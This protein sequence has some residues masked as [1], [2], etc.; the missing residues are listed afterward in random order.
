MVTYSLLLIAMDAQAMPDIIAHRCGTKELPENTVFA[1]EKLVI[2]GITNIEIDLQLTKDGAP[3]LYHADNLLKLNLD[4]QISDYTYGELAE[5]FWIDKR[6]PDNKLAIPTLEEILV[7]FPKIYFVID[8]KSIPQ[9]ALV[10]AVVAI[11]DKHQAWDRLLFY[12]TDD[13]HIQLLK[14][15]APQAVAFESRY[16]TRTRLLSVI[17]MHKC[18]LPSS[19][20]WLGF[21]RVREMKITESFKLGEQSNQ[22]AMYMWTPEAIACTRKQAPKTCIVWFGVNDIE[23]YEDANKGGADAIFTDIPLLLLNYVK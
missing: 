20:P 21:E 2:A 12:S 19:A 22:V 11:I 14:Q 23:A 3:V 18:I 4:G 8:F 10:N 6:F 16:N 5:A 1:I 9:E 7:K 13:L 15:K 17:I